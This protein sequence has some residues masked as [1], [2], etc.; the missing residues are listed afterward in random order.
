[1]FSSNSRTNG[2]IAVILP[3]VGGWVIG[4]MVDG[5]VDKIEKHVIWKTI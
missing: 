3:L 2:K 4:G 5:A 1:M